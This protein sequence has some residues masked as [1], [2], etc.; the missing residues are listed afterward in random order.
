MRK[1]LLSVCFA[2]ISLGMH[3]SKANSLPVVVTQPDGTTLTVML[4]GD[5][6]VSWYTALDGTLLVNEGGNYYVA[7]VSDNGSLTASSI[8]AHDPLQRTQTEANLALA[9]DKLA[10]VRYASPLLGQAGAPSLFAQHHGLTKQMQIRN[11]ST[12]FPRVGSPKA[13]VILVEFS[14]SLFTI[15][16]PKAS[17]N[18]YLNN[19]SGDIANRG[20]GENKNP[21]GVRGY[22]KDISFGKFS[23]EFDL[24]GPVR[25]Q[26]P[27][28]YYGAG[29]DNTNALVRDACNAIDDSVDF[30]QYDSNNDGYVDLVYVI[31]AGHSESESGNNRNDIWPKSGYG[32]F[33]T[34]DGKKVYRYGVNNE[35]NGRETSRN[36]YIN[37][38]GLFCHEFSHCMGLPDVYATDGS[39]GYNADNFGMEYWDVMDGGEYVRSGRYPTAYTAWEREVMGWTSVDTL[40]DT[41]HVEMAYIDKENDSLARAY[42]VVNPSVSNEAFYL[43]N[44]QNQGWNRYLPGHGLLAY[45]VSYSKDD[46]YF[47]DNPNNGSKPRI[48][49]IPA[50]G[51]LGAMASYSGDPTPENYYADMAGDTYPGTTGNDSIPFFITYAGDSIVKPLLNIKEENEIVSFDFLGAKRIVDAIANVKVDNKADGK[52]YNINGQFVG[53]D[54]VRLPKGLY[55]MNGKK[56][57]L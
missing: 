29:N 20:N 34:Y 50:D 26:H 39:V 48:V 30:S 15:S 24:V 38:I 1:I 45:R 51:R 14:D 2:L 27:M 37:G 21:K 35:L 47:L 17:F 54:P 41:T 32:S 56:V 3:A 31:Y 16:N 22:F 13:L 18:D 11:D 23:P 36:K 42:K 10:F 9:Q 4:H 8:L 19:E 55:I 5:E 49:C 43:Q 40:S 7:E 6:N 28:S 57:I 53:T 12:L 46:V 52:I 25:L 33:G 44:I